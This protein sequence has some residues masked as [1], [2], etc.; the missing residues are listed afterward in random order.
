M[1]PLAAG[2]YRASLQ[3][4]NGVLDSQTSVVSILVLTT[5]GTDVS[6]IRDF[7]QACFGK[8]KALTP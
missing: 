5:I 8:V 4:S 2:R 6:V 3:V 1:T 7:I